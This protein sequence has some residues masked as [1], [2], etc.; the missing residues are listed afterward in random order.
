FAGSGTTGHAA[1]ELNRKDGGSRQF[2]LCTN[3]ENGIAENVTYPRIKNVIDGYADVNGIPANVRYFKTSLVG[4][5]Q[6]DDQTRIELVVLSTDMMCHREYPFEKVISTKLFNVFCNADHYAAIVFE[7]YAIALR[8]DA[9]SKLG[10][11]KP[12]HIYVF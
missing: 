2:I 12:I 7:P 8:N 1:L 6:T 10:D 5:Q 9:L 3:N 11:D 4:K